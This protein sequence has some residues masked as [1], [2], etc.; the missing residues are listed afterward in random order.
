MRM[1]LPRAAALTAPLLLAAITALGHAISAGR[2]VAEVADRKPGHR[3]D[4][5]NT[6]VIFC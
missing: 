3:L 5:I 4:Q 6:I 1:S 2:R